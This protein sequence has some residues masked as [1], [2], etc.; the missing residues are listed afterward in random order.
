MVCQQLHETLADHS[1]RPQNSHP[2]SPARRLVLNVI[3][4]RPSRR[5]HEMDAASRDSRSP[6]ETR[7]IALPLATHCPSPGSQ[8]TPQQEL[9]ALPLPEIAAISPLSF[10]RSCHLSLSRPKL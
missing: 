3:Q 5:N 9:M 1:R 7:P 4:N 6:S 10:G 8:R 2:Y